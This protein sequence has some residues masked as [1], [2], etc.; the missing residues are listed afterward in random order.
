MYYSTDFE[1]CCF[2]RSYRGAI[3]PGGLVVFDMV[4]LAFDQM[5]I[6]KS[7]MARAPV[8]G[9][10]TL[11]GRDSLEHVA[12]LVDLAGCNNLSDEPVE[13]LINVS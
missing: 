9:F 2:L 1:L 11:L 5:Q 4:D 7:A 10:A 12:P 8:G 13:F 3:D 6:I